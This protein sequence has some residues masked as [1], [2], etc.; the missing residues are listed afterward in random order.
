MSGK[1]CYVDLWGNWVFET[2]K[3][4]FDEIT[5]SNAEYHHRHGNGKDSL[6]KKEATQVQNYKE[7]ELNSPIDVVPGKPIR[8][9]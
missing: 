2:L 4:S 1:L 8:R 9:G 6:K 7:G 5:W 3:G